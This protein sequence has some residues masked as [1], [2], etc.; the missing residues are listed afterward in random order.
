[1]TGTAGGFTPAST[2]TEDTIKD[3]TAGAVL[4][5]S[6]AGASITLSAE[7]TSITISNFSSL[8]LMVLEATGD[9]FKNGKAYMVVPPQGTQTMNFTDRL[10]STDADAKTLIKAL[11]LVAVPLASVT[12]TY[13]GDATLFGLAAIPANVTALA[14]INANNE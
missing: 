5:D 12:N 4:I 11:K 10:K 8:D 3:G 2:L 13:Q 7:Q 6:A 9:E 14:V 1:M